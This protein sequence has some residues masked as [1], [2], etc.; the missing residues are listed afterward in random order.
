MGAGLAHEL[1]NPLAGVLGLVQVLLARAADREL[2][3]LRA[4]EEQALRCREIV[5]RLLRF[6]EPD[7]PSAPLETSARPVVDLHGVV[8]EVVELVLPSFRQRGVGLAWRSEGPLPVRG[9]RKALAQAL[10]QLLATLRAAAV[11]G[12]TVGIEG[13]SAPGSVELRID[14][15]AVETTAKKDDWMASGLGFWGAQQVLAEH[16]GNLV[17]PAERAGVTGPRTWRV[18]LPRA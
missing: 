15:L 12:S 7:R 17:E 10:A 3:L 18:V 2:P 4:A 11:P 5:A 6:T 14:M 1:N 16:G 8:A 13:R 9:E